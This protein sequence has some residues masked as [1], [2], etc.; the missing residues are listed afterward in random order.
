MSPAPRTTTCEI[1]S[2]FCLCKNIYTSGFDAPSLLSETLATEACLRLGSGRS[3]EA[4]DEPS[5]LCHCH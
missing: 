1:R 4:M 5:I 2:L 3:T